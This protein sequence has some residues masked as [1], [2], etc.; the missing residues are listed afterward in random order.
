MVPVATR[1]LCRVH[2]TVGG[3]F[4]CLFDGAVVGKGTDAD[5]CGDLDGGLC[6]M[7]RPAELCQQLRCN[8]RKLFPVA[9]VGEYNAEFI[10]PLAADGVTVPLA[11]VI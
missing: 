7:K 10:S 1:F 6:Q 9:A 11:A 4:Q 3:D 5:T 2:C 8:C